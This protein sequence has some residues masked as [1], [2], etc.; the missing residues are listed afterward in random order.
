MSTET[1]PFE[2]TSAFQ[3]VVEF[4]SDTG[5]EVRAMRHG[6]GSYQVMVKAGAAYVQRATV[7][8]KGKGETPLR[9]WQA[10]QAAIAESEEDGDEAGEV[11]W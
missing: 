9:I 6:A 1:K 2:D 11:E 4:V 3:D 8:L 10:F 7:H 5:Q